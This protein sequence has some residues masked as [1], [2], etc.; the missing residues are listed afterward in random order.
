MPAPTIV[1]TKL[2]S[3]R[4]T[5]DTSSTKI[6]RTYR[7]TFSGTA[8]ENDAKTATVPADLS[9]II[10]SP[11]FVAIDRGATP[12]DKTG[13]VRWDLEVT[14]VPDGSTLQGK[15]AAAAVDDK[16]NV[17]VNITTEPHEVPQHKSNDGKVLS[18]PIGESYNYSRIKRTQVIKVQFSTQQV[19]W[20]AFEAAWDKVNSGSVTMT[21][22]GSSRTFVAKT[23]LFA[24]CSLGITFDEGVPTFDVELVLHYNPDTWQQHFAMMSRFQIVSSKIVPIKDETG[25]DVTEPR[26]IGFAGVPIP[27]GDP[28][29]FDDRDCIGEVDFSDLLD[30]VP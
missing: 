2:I 30:Q 5:T 19:D 17:R 3:T 29:A 20:T 21:V 11:N 24:D 28:I 18:N 6:V 9:A 23:L 4:Y 8:T 10:T 22:G 13:E 7:I 1:S 12:V 26:Y 25:Q 14:Y 15:P 27:H 16:W